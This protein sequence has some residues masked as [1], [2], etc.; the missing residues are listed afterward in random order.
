MLG[1]QR[2]NKTIDPQFMDAAWKNMAEILDQEMPVEMKERRIG[3]LSIAAILVMGFVGGIVAT[4]GLQKHQSAPMASNRTLEHKTSQTDIATSNIPAS[5]NDIL[6][7]EIQNEKNITL[8]SSAIIK[9]T[10]NSTVSEKRI[11]AATI[12][13]VKSSINNNIQSVSSFTQKKLS[14]SIVSQPVKLAS[15]SVIKLPGEEKIATDAV[16]TVSIA[17]PAI[18]KNSTPV[19]GLPVLGLTT[20]PTATA[21]FLIGDDIDLPKNKKWQTGIYAGVIVAGKTGNGLEAG[22]KL[23]RKLGAKWAIE[24]GLGFRGTQL[25]F[26][27]KNE[28]NSALLDDYRNAITSDPDSFLASL[29][30]Q[31]IVNSINADAPDYQVTVPL[32]LL[33]R[34]TGKLRL[35]LGMSWAY[36]LNKLKDAS[37]LEPSVGTGE[38]FADN[39]LDKNSFSERSND[40]RLNLGVGY[41]FNNCMAIELAYS[42]QL[43]FEGNHF[44]DSANAS[45]IPFY[46]DATIPGKFFRLGWIYYFRG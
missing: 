8:S 26:L 22:M 6:N 41:H 42:T 14:Q 39:S 28:E 16:I 37:S 2:K 3:W 32:S 13:E 5:K 31:E 1:K 27:S 9:E 36:R 23:Q 34:P 46:D 21:D 38:F 19:A 44:L 45:T 10:A 4:W 7:T 24:T 12:K 43:N 20:L 18:A 33:Y 15:S 29:D 40:F 17:D 25:A 11:A 30:Q 35:A